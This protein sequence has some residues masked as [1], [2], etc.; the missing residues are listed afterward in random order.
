MKRTFLLVILI[1]LLMA[2]KPNVTGNIPTSS[3]EGKGYYVDQS[4]VKHFGK[5]T[6]F[7]PI[8]QPDGKG[9][10][11]GGLMIKDKEGK[12]GII[13]NEINHVVIS[14][15]VYYPRKN[16]NFFVKGYKFPEREYNLEYVFLER[17]AIGKISYHVHTS[18]VG[19]KTKSFNWE[20]NLLEK[21][22]KEF[23]LYECSKDKKKKE[24]LLELI[25]DDRE[26]YEK[27]IK[28]LKYSPVSKYLIG[29]MCKDYNE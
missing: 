3:Y 12:R 24:C 13:F 17:I 16:L 19:E 7:Y 11:T 26:V 21:D 9:H 18:V 5:L 20:A 27:Y 28:K 8:E 29:E 2:L 4:G 25:K 15:R 10:S 14:S 23:P 6:L 1:P 22:D